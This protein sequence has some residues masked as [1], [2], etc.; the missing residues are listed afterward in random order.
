[1]SNSNTK[2]I[3]DELEE[4]E[5]T[6]NNSI[7]YEYNRS[8][9]KSPF[10]YENFEFRS[11]VNPWS[12]QPKF[13]ADF[14]KIKC[15][16][17][18]LLPGKFIYIPA[19]WWYSFKFGEDTSVSYLSYRTYM[20]NVAISPN[21]IMYALQNQNIKREVVKKIDIQPSSKVLEPDLAKEEHVNEVSENKDLD[22]N[23]V[24][25]AI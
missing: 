24:N 19:Y 13:S 22:S 8:S 18:T 2:K 10:D 16:E 5:K 6:C 20:N 7:I 11:P 12:V 14:D 3:N 17:I 1:M 21:I 9:K 23:V 25:D 4:R 15:L